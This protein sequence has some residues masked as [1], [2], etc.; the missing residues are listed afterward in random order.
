MKAFVTG[1]TG[2]L[3][4]NLIHLL[5]QQGHEVKALV[6]SKDKAL[7]LFKELN[8]Q[9]VKGDMLD[10]S[11]FASELDECDIVFHTAA[12][13]R[14]AFQPGNH[15][16]ML[17]AVNIRGTIDLL[18]EAEKRD[19]KKV[20]YVS[21]AGVVGKGSSGVPGDEST[22][23]SKDVMEN[24]YFK[25]KVIAEDSI[26][27]FLKSHSLQVVLILPAWMFGPGDAAPTTSGQLVLDYVHEKLPGIVDGGSC[28]VDVRDTAQAMLTAVEKGKSGERYIV[29]GNHVTM[30]ELVHALEEVTAV[31]APRF[32]IPHA[33]LMALA[34]ASEIYGSLTNS[35]ILISRTGVKS[36]NQKI[37]LS[38]RK[39]LQ[40]LGISFRPLE[41]TLRDEVEW[42]RQH[43]YL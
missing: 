15:W 36:L 7:Q 23:P 33:V 22:P 42:Y 12:Y 9:I 37:Q 8:V 1:S 6:R 43:N 20:I 16:E 13:F 10:V 34:W 25:S 30:T 4:Y 11:S 29:G 14:E 27:E 18:C 19:V 2:L 17:E 39:A 28:I 21:S 38:S 32:H 3:G 26:H 41:A 5:L 35:P 24:L 31:S 40:E